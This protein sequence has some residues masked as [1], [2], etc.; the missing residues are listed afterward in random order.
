MTLELDSAREGAFG[1]LV[2]PFVHPFIGAERP[3]HPLEVLAWLVRFAADFLAAVE[4][5]VALVAVSV[6]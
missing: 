2:I 1:A 3:V 6:D 5:Q 4:I